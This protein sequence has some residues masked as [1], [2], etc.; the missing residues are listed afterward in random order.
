MSTSVID[1]RALRATFAYLLIALLCAAA[2]A[3]YEVFSHGVWSGYMV[4]AFLFPL[5]LGALPMSWIALRGQS[6]PPRWTLNF[7][8]AGVATLTVGSF[9]EGALAIYGTT[10]QLTI[11]YWI[12]G[13]AL[14]LLG[15][16]IWIV[17][18]L[19]KA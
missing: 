7:H 13:P 15:L 9:F 17:H 4:Y 11:I 6:M 14:I 1:P 3:V 18:R 16:A 10:H 5:A 12:V 8:G 19:K 2:G